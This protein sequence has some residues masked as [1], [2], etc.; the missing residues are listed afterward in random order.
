MYSGISQGFSNEG[1]MNTPRVNSRILLGIYI[2]VSLGAARFSLGISFVFVLIIIISIFFV[3]GVIHTKHEML[4]TQNQSAM[5]A[6]TCK[7]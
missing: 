7:Q 4:S 6:F 5:G 1:S 3:T 2:G